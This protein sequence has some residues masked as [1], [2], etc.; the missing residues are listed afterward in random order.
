MS[1][2]D[3]DVEACRTGIWSQRDAV[4]DTVLMHEPDCLSRRVNEAGIRLVGWTVADF[5]TAA[6][7]D[8]P[9]MLGLA[10]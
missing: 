3:Q 1:Q 2:Y 5:I 10:S 7:F 8:D 6:L 4:L 9:T